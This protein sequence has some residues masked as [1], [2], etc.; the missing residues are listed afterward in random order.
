MSFIKEETLVISAI[1]AILTGIFSFLVL[2]YF[3]QGAELRDHDV[4]I[5]ALKISIANEIDAE[6]RTEA[7]IT[8]I[9]QTQTTIMGAL[10]GL[11]DA[12]DAQT[13]TA[14]NIKDQ[15]LDLRKQFA[16]IDAVLRPLRPT[17]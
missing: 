7:S 6:R 10:Q 12:N 2:N 13:A 8:A 4:A 16:D 17:R 14:T 3:S 5:A 9:E 11:K 15:L 1:G